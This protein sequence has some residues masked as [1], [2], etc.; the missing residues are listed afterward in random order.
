MK[1][2]KTP[3]PILQPP[4]ELL[5]SSY[6]HFLQAE[7]KPEARSE[8]LHEVFRSIFPV[9]S[10]DG[11]RSLEFVSYTLEVPKYNE[12]ECLRLGI[13]YAAPLKVTVRLLIFA[14]NESPKIIENLMEQEVYFG[15]LPLL[16]KRGTFIID[17]TERCSPTSM[18]LRADRL[19][20]FIRDEGLPECWLLG[21]G[22]IA[23]IALAKSGAFRCSS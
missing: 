17:G 2:I 18:Q 4:L 8:G 3:A 22:G 23:K 13:N 20:F 21:Q 9:V 14:I 10:A 19:Y 1:K 5:R 16:T 15:E 6:Q 12:A 7:K 11:A